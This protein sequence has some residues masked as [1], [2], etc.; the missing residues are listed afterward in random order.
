MAVTD[1]PTKLAVVVRDD[2]EPWQRLNVTAF[3]LSGVTAAED[4]VVGEPYEDA[5]GVRCAA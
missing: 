1:F 3:L 5:D 2:L 4:G